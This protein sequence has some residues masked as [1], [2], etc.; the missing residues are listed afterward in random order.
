MGLFVALTFGSSY[1]IAK[2]LL[3][4]VDP[5]VF[6][7]ARFLLAGALMLLLPLEWRGWASIAVSGADL[8]RL[9]GLGLVGYTLFHGVWGVGLSLTTPAKA[10]LIVATTP[11]FGAMFAACTGDRLSPVG[12]FGVVLSF[13]GV[14]VVVNDSVTELRL[15]DGTWLGDALFVVA[16]ALWALYGA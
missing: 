11:V 13:V 9:F 1:P 12:W 7:S 10:V 3:A 8:V 16:A 14:F 6:S 4:V 2:P 15:G 5:F